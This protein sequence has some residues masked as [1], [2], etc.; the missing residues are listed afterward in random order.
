MVSQGDGEDG[1]REPTRPRDGEPPP[2]VGELWSGFDP[3]VAAKLDTDLPGLADEIV[4]AV[5]E[6]PA[7][8]RPLTG[9]FGRV[10][11][12]GVEVALRRFVDGIA[13]GDA[14]ALGPSRQVY[15]D[16][17]R[18]EFEAGRPLDLLLR[19]YRLGARIAWRRLAERGPGL[20]LEPEVLYRLAESVFA[21]IDELSA[22]SV[23]GYSQARDV[24][25][26]TQQVARGRLIAML[27]SDPQPE[28]SR[29][30]AEAE[31][32]GWELPRL[33]AVICSERAAEATRVA[34][35]L[36]PGVIGAEFDGR[37][38]LLVGDPERPG[39]LGQARV[40]LDGISSAIGPAVA[41]RD[42]PRSYRRASQALRIASRRQG[43]DRGLEIAERMLIPIL[44]A[45]EPELGNELIASRLGP[46]AEMSARSRRGMPETLASWLANGGDIARV[47]DELEVHPQTVR[48]R[49]RKL[50]DAFGDSLDDPEARF[51]LQLALRFET[52][53]S[54]DRVEEEEE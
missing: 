51:E 44:L 27:V 37:G 7:Y 46:I 18:F 40:A 35:R 22:V 3:A 26:G 9:E 33:L 47:A 16:L 19:A 21:Y 8:S 30:T 23:E 53:A 43:P 13:R 12:T 5:T 36:G 39:L 48:Y 38:C 14:D 29:V 25:A 24:A 54:E 42:A 1:G 32:A 41:W 17:G 2:A 4:A 45:S 28:P 20:G 50:R 34:A 49:M 31:R 52:E 11:R 10:L 6:L 15:L